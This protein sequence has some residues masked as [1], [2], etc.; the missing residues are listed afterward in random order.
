MLAGNKGDIQKTP[1]TLVGARHD[2]ACAA[3]A[4]KLFEKGA[5]PCHCARVMLH[6][7]TPCAASSTGGFSS[8]FFGIYSQAWHLMPEQGNLSTRLLYASVSCGSSAAVLVVLRSM[9]P[10][11]IPKSLH[12]P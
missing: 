8:V 10:G 3:A 6:A 1:E 12:I 11:M 2:T 4:N 7:P 5:Y 9:G